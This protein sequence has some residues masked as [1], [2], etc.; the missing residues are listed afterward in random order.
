MNLG[1]KFR[2]MCC[3]E[4]EDICVHF[5]K[6]AHLHEELSALG[7]TVSDDKC[8]TPLMGSLVSPC[9]DGPPDS[10]LSSFNIDEKRVL[11]DEVKTLEEAQCCRNQGAQVLGKGW[12]RRR[13]RAEEIEGQRDQRQHGH[14]QHRRDQ[15]VVRRRAWGS[16]RRDRRCSQGGGEL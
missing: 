14:S 2:T 12:R 7:C 4:G 3:G 8:P 16:N 9:Y 13:W 1:K 5:D 10:P 6:V 11:R 15:G